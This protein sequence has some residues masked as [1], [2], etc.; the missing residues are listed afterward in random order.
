MQHLARASSSLAALFLVVALPSCAIEPGSSAEPIVGGTVGGDPAVLWLYNADEGGS[1]TAVLVTPRVVL[2]AKHCIQ[3]PGWETPSRPTS[4]VL[5]IGDSVGR[6]RTLRVQSVYTTPGVWFDDRGLSGALVGQDVAAIVLTTGVTDVTPIPI[7]MTDIGDLPGQEFT[8]IGFGQIPSGRAGTKYTATGRVFSVDRD[9]SLIFVNE[10]TCQGD[11]GGPMVTREG[12]V[13]GVVSFGNGS[14]GTGYGA[15]N[16]IY[17]YLDIIG[18]AFDE[19]G[20]CLNDGPE[21]CDGQDN[22]CN[23]QVD[24]TCTP[25]GGPC[26]ADDECVGTTCRATSAGSICTAQCD[27]RRPDFGC[28]DG[29]FCSRAEPG[30]CEGW[31]VPLATP[32]TLPIDA[33]C[34]SDDQCA[35]RYCADPGDGRSRCLVSCGVGT[36]MCLA[37]DVCVAYVGACGGCVPAAIVS[38]LPHTLGEPCDA[39]ADCASAGTCLTDGSAHYCSRACDGGMESCPRGYHCRAMSCVRGTLG[40]LGEP[41]STNEDCEAGTFCAVRGAQSWCT[42]LCTTSVPCPERFDCVPAG[43]VMVCAP[44]GGLVG[45]ECDAA[46]D[47]ISGR[48]EGAVC[49][50]ECGV[51]APCGPGFECRASGGEAL[52]VRPALPSGGCSASRG[53]RE[54]RASAMLVVAAVL[55]AASWRRRRSA[56]LT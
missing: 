50:R 8:A 46:L 22:D 42:Q 21:I 44:T 43:E 49:V 11:S 41:C 17:N 30:S 29:Q 40:G 39:D 37:G 19:A 9:R 6:G 12:E 4:I 15:Y 14:C 55:A 34:T 25:I 26:A 18:M 7:R 16:A 45:D 53:R 31:C 54:T 56:P 35:S 20:G 47:C 24:E 3:P 33:S 23:G 5:G 32:G 48:C 36:G 38:G 2:T 52:C 27:A 28:G 1:C 51:D 10:V 13:A